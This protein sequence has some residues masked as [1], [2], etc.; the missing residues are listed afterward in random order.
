MATQSMHVCAHDW[1]CVDCMHYAIDDELLDTS[2][3]RIRTVQ[4]GRDHRR[5]PYFDAN[6][7]GHRDFDNARCDACGTHLAGD[8]YR[9]ARLLPGESCSDACPGPGGAQ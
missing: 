2:P 4:A 3:A 9:F 1:L 8:R 6:G 5:V 7:E